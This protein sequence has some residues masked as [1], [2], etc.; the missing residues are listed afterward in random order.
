MTTFFY[1][2][3]YIITVYLGLA[4]TSHTQEPLVVGNGHN[5]RNNGTINPDLATV[6]QKFKEYISIIEKLCHNQI[7]SSVN[8]FHEPTN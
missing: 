8:L 5:S 7:C 6:I 1:S 3:S 4:E 2:A